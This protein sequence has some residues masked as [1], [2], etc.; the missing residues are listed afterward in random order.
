MH[1]TSC[2]EEEFRVFAADCIDL[3]KIALIVRSLVDKTTAAEDLDVVYKA[4]KQCIV[5][6][7]LNVCVVA[8]TT[9]R[10]DHLRECIFEP[11][12]EAIWLCSE[13]HDVYKIT[14]LRCAVAKPLST[15]AELWIDSLD[16]VADLL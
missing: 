10:P 8:Q 9:V 1:E 3:S 11:L 12:R 13:L 16:V 2:S 5:C 7:T 6:S 4:L 15:E 14:E